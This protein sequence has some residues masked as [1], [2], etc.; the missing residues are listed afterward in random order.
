MPR[1]RAYRLLEWLGDIDESRVI[2]QRDFGD[3]RR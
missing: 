2:E 3:E 1:N